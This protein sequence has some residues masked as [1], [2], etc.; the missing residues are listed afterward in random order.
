MVQR[1]L[2]TDWYNHTVTLEFKQQVQEAI[3]DE[4]AKLVSASESIPA[5]DQYKRGVIRGLSTLLEWVPEFI[6]DDENAD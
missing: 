2:F 4:V 6:K 1:E 5:Y 3:E